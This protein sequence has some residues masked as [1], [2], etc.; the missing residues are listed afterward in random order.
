MKYLKTYKLFESVV[1]GSNTLDLYSDG[2]WSKVND[3]IVY[4]VVNYDI[5]NWPKLPE[6]L[7]TLICVNRDI[8]YLPELPKHLIDLCVYGNKLTE[9]PKLPKSL[10]KLYCQNNQL[11][12]LPKLPNNLQFLNCAD[13]NIKI[14]PHFPKSL[15]RYF[16]LNNPLIELPNDITEYFIQLQRS[17]YWFEKIAYN[18]IV[19]KTQHYNLLKEYLSDEDI[20]KL[21]KEH[22]ELLAQEQFGMFGLKNK[23]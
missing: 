4:L 23:E 2:D 16:I 14:L 7:K 19:N 21:E 20:E 13:N 6:K 5:K 3:S 22:S 15:N 8:K 17:R 1:K 18:C 10:Q 11:T 9:L 12:E